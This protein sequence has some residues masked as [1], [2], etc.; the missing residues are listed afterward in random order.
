MALCLQGFRGKGYS[1][2]FVA[3]MT[4]VHRELEADRDRPVRLTTSPDRLCA[5]CPNLKGQGC[6]LQSPTHESHMRAQDEEVL[7][8]LGLEAGGVY[9]W[10]LVL[11]R[12]R[13]SIRGSDL[14]AICTTCPWL[15][16]GWCA[17]GVD[18]LRAPAKS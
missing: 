13:E 6:T 16:L 11:E 7:R 2:S 10:S 9:P 14:P 17:E 1:G 12:I 3:E 18:A 15:G 5:V 4:S 8:R